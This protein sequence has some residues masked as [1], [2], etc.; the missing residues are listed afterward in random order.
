MTS[1]LLSPAVVRGAKRPD[2]ITSCQLMANEALKLSRLA[3]TLVADE[4]VRLAEQWLKLAMA[5][6]SEVH[7]GPQQQ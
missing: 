3:S 7:P 2:Q 6:G 5:L 1:G 4:Y